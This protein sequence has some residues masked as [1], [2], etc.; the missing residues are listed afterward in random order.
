MMSNKRQK[1][2]K[3]A[4]THQCVLKL[5]PLQYPNTTWLT[6][7]QRK[8]YYLGLLG[9]KQENSHLHPNNNCIHFH[10]QPVKLFLFIY[11]HCTV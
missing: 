11:C 1:V 10:D 5:F 2:L 9:G 3:K 6:V 7:P 8:Q 4:T